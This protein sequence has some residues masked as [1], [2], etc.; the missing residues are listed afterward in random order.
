MK[1]RL[2]LTGLACTLCLLCWVAIAFSALGGCAHPP[3]LEKVKS[4]SSSSEEFRKMYAAAEAEIKKQETRLFKN[5][6]RAKELIEAIAAGKEITIADPP[7]VQPSGTFNVGSV[8]IEGYKFAY[9]STGSIATFIDR[10]GR[11]IPCE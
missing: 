2:T 3:D 9:T 6:D 8:C 1:P 4:R 10:A 7:Q 5:Y 11:G